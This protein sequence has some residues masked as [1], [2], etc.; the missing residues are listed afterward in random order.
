MTVSHDCL[1]GGLFQTIHRDSSLP[2][3]GDTDT[4][5]DK[6]KGQQQL[7]DKAAY[8]WLDPHECAP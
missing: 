2:S 6:L 4:P 7:K 3:G 8:L 1:Y 5:S